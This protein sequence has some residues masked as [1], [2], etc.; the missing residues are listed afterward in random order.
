MKPFTFDGITPL[1]QE[2][3]VVKIQNLAGMLSHTAGCHCKSHNA[4]SYGE[5]SLQVSI[6]VLYTHTVK[7][8]IFAGGVIFAIF[9]I[10]W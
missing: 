9:A 4:G 3:A 2:V 10:F 5:Y 7:F 8:L 1:D 6:H